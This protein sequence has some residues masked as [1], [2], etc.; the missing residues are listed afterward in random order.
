[1]NAL[2]ALDRIRIVLTQPSHPGNIGAAARAM[3]TMGLSRLVLIDPVSFPH[4]D[5]SARASGATDVLDEAVLA[6][7]LEQA[8]QATVLTVAMTARRRELAAPMLPVRE[9]AAELVSAAAFGDVAV[10][11]GNETHG[12]SNAELGLCR[13]PAMIPANPAYASLNL[14]AA[15]QVTCYELRLAATGEVSTPS[16][17]AQPA[18]FDDTERL[19]AH[20]ERAM[21]E[22]GFLDPVKPGRLMP[23]LRRLF[24]RARLEREE[25]NILRGM[26]NALQNKVE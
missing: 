22:S 25:V 20:F 1:M 5:A 12:L 8:L 19:F 14:A 17:Q 26:L 18:S 24:A 13:H 23:R 3:K 4:P 6:V 15:V 11:F 2:A 9:A 21:I 7:S 16:R 10:V